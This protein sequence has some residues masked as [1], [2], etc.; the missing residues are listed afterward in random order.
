V[1][2]RAIT[3]LIPHYNRPELLEKALLSIREQTSPAAEVLVL[4][5]CSR[6]EVLEQIRQLSHLATIH[7]N[8]R[9]L[10]LRANFNQGASLA[11]TEW[12]G[13]LADD[14][15]FLPQKLERQNAYLDEHPECDILV[16]PFWM[17]NEDEGRREIWGFR[18][19]RQL[20][21]KDA[22]VHT[23][24][25]Q[26]ALMRRETF[27]ALDGIGEPPLEDQDF[28]I[29]AI[30]AGYRME[31]LPEPLVVYRRWGNEQLSR[32][33][34]RTYR[35][36]MAMIRRYRHLY[37]QEFGPLGPLKMYARQFQRYGLRRG[38][39]AGKAMW[40]AGWAMQLALGNPFRQ[41]D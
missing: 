17:L 2:A 3:I 34:S 6:P 16:G 19:A 22:L 33:W 35:A 31:V 7:V 18:E 21:L 28:G 4:D 30:L 37:R 40:A 39:Y 23:T 20:T 32:N 26:T 38:Q 29:R 24:V 11:R 9:N 8:E 27:L 13:F 1:P 14:D 25:I 5:D 41:W 36:Q 10:G 12:L 15:L